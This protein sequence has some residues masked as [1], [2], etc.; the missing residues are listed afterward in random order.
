M[1]NVKWTSTPFNLPET[2]ACWENDDGTFASGTRENE[3]LAAWLAAGN[4]IPQAN[5]TIDNVAAERDRRLAFGFDYDFGDA[6][7]VHRIG[8]TDADMKGWDEVTKA[9]QAAIAIGAA[10]TE[11]NIVTSTGPAT[12]TALEWQRVLLAATAARQPLWAA[13]FALEAANPIP[14]DYAAD[15]H[16]TAQAT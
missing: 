8:T 11:F 7:G 9:S 4:A 6:R 10:A 12:L 13:S 16:W 15:S 2:V 3:Q 5:P 1:K 14:A